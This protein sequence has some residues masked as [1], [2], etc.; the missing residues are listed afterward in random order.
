M[1]NADQWT[2]HYRPFAQPAPGFT[3]C[4]GVDEKR[5][6]MQDARTGDDAIFAT[7]N[8]AIRALRAITAKPQRKAL[9]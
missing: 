4:R 7:K 3:V 9:A 5:E 2:I 6:Y 8:E 1:T